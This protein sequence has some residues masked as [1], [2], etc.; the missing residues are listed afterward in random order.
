MGLAA[1]LGIA[2]LASYLGFGE[3]LTMFLTALLIGMV[4]LVIVGF[5]LRRVRGGTPQPVYGGAASRLLLGMRVRPVP[6][7]MWAMK[8]PG[9]CAARLGASFRL[10]AHVPALRWINSR[11]LV[12]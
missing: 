9:A 12:R 1:G 4:L 10:R 8:V 7:N 2:A 11:A 3:A 6:I 5:I